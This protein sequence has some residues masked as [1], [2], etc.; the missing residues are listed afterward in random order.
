MNNEI[1]EKVNKIFL[2]VDVNQSGIVD[3]SGKLFEIK[4]RIFDGFD[5]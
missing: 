5:G 4:I 2:K 3:F 1:Q